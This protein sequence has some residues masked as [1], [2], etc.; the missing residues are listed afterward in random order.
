MKLSITGGIIDS[1]GYIDDNAFANDETGQFMNDMFVNST[2]ANLPSYDI[3]GAAELEIRDF[4][5]KTVVVNSGNEED[6]NYNYYALQL[7]Y[8]PNTPLNQGNYLVYGRKR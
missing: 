6:E 5:V 7:G 4:S 8:S 1:T 3:G 2:L